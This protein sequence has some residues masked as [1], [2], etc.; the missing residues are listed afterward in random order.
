MNA[1]GPSPLGAN[2]EAQTIS[3]L[4]NQRAMEQDYIV[5]KNQQV[6]DNSSTGDSMNT[7]SMEYSSY[8]DE[9][10]IRSSGNTTNITIGDN[11]SSNRSGNFNQMEK[12]NVSNG[13]SSSRSS[14]FQFGRL[15]F[16]QMGL[17]GWERRKRTNLLSRTDKL[18]RE[19]RNLDAQKCRET[20][21]VAVIFVANGQEDKNSILRLV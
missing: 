7:S 4:L 11:S 6:F 12:T 3:I 2:F 17:A 21:K 13:K 14:P 9:V 19:L 5:R 1:P 18:L 20:H 16:S 15:M 8:S 10:T